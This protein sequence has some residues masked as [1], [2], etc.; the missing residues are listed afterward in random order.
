MNCTLTQSGVFLCSKF[1][2]LDKC[3]PLCPSAALLS[4]ER[5]AQ[6]DAEPQSSGPSESEVALQEALNSLQQEKDALT[7]QYKAQVY[8]TL[9]HALTVLFHKYFEFYMTVITVICF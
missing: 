9:A 6:N 5:E 2:K 1:I 8:I 7:A 3:H 4:Q